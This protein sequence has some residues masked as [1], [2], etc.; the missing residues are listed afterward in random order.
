VKLVADRRFHRIRQT[1]E[2]GR[3]EIIDLGHLLVRLTR[4]IDWEFLDRRFACVCA[5]GR[6]SPACRPPFGRGAVRALAG[7]P[8][9][10]FLLRRA[11][12]LPP[13]A[14]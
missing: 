9:L 6:V 13:A 14:V 1:L 10:P 12:L 2:Y 8:V 7:K 3:Q 4:E 5:P 11:E